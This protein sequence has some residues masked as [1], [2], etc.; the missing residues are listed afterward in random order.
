LTTTRHRCNLDC[1]GLGA[2]SRRW[3][4]LTRDSRKGIKGL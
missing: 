3:A 2:K 1:V 4:S